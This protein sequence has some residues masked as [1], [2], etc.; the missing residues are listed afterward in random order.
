MVPV[1]PPT[2]FYVADFNASQT[3]TYAENGEAISSYNLDRST[4]KPRGIASNATGTLQWTVDTKGNVT[5]YDNTGS[6]LGTWLAQNLSKPEGITVSGND[7]WIVD[8]GTDRVYKFT[9]GANVRSGRVAATSSF[10]LN[11]ANTSPM[12]LVTDGTRI[13]VLNDTVGNDRVFR[14]STTGTLQGN[15]GLSVT[16]PS[17][18]GITLDPN[19]VNH[20]WTVDS[21]TR[22]VYQY[23]GAT[24]LTTG[25]LEPSR[26]F[27]LAPT[28]VNPQGIADPLFEMHARSKATQH[29]YIAPL[30]VNHDGQ[31]NA[32]DV[33]DLLSVLSHDDMTASLDSIFADVNDDSFVTPLDALIVVNAM[34]RQQNNPLAQNSSDKSLQWS[35]PLTGARVG[36]SEVAGATS[37]SWEVLI[38]KA[39]AQQ[40][41]SIE[42]DGQVLGVA[43]TDALGRGRLLIS[44]LSTVADNQETLRRWRA[45]SSL[46]LRTNSGQLIAD[47]RLQ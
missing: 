30:D 4:N 27:A 7:L 16:N 36:I 14:Y 8:N 33:Q 12:D 38:D 23:D 26:A 11:S 34:N 24:A 40:L 17:P 29:N 44:D 28:N 41:L 31:V 13:W 22:K 37:D 1:V 19:N 5:V 18:T 25:T 10:A 21:S 45:G 20:L 3:F 43:T 42:I 39:P 6:M 9:N 35:S 2:K 47:F 32:L 15:W 46:S